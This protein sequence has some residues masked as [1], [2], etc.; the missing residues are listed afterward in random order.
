MK[1]MR[2]TLEMA[3][4]SLYPAFVVVVVFVSIF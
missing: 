4:F 3:L 2:Q 1:T